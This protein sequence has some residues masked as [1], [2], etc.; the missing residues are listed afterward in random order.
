[1]SPA[2][3]TLLD[4]WILERLHT[5][6]AEC[7]KAY[8]TYEF[9]KVFNALNQFCTTDLSAIYIDATKDRMYCDA[10]DSPRR[11]ASQRA[12]HDIF[13][14]TARLLAPILAFTAD[15]AWE[16][17]CFTTGSVHEQDFPDADP[18]FAPGSATH[19]A[20]RLFEIKYVIQTAIEARIQAREFTRNNEADV[21]LTVPGDDAHLLP[22]LNDR[23]FATEFFIIANL[24][25]T[26]GD[27]LAATARM[28]DHHLCPRCRKHEPLVASGLCA[29]CDSVIGH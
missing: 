17:A 22:L 13:T 27:S 14:A 21:D 25:A 20:G 5:V 8:E 26:T 9:R 1:V 19:Q 3:V 24:R 28:T 2:A 12:M 23:E 15:E 16:H 10:V 11:R 29:R 4:R 7:R 18:A 6:V